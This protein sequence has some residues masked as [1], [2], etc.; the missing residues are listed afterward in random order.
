MIQKINE[1]KSCFFK[2]N[3]IDKPL[4]R[5]IKIQRENIQINTFINL[6]EEIT[7]ETEKYKGLKENTTNNYI[8]TNWI[9]R[10]KWKIS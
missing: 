3:K 8:P 7:T 1:N 2:I 10:K 9:M 6:R 4:T 5:F